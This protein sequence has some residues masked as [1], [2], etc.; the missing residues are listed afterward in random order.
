[1]PI[2]Q[3]RVGVFNQLAAAAAPLVVFKLKA[4]CVRM[5]DGSITNPLETIAVTWY[6][7]ILAAAEER[8]ASSSASRS[9]FWVMGTSLDILEFSPIYRGQACAAV[10]S[11][12]LAAGALP[13]ELAFSPLHLSNGNAAGETA[14]IHVLTKAPADAQSEY[15]TSQADVCLPLSQ[16]RGRTR[17]R[18]HLSS[19]RQICRNRNLPRVN[20]I[21][22]H[23]A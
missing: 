19:H 6:I 23:N 17:W 20:R 12:P 7:K 18:R 2:C 11:N 13:Y 14:G 21:H 10:A 22:R 4:P 5:I 1:M 16:K 8:W 3:T 9:N 15:R